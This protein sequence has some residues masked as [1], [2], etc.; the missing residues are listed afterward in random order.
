M[1]LN[2]LHVIFFLVKLIFKT[3]EEIKNNFLLLNVRHLF[4]SCV[5]KKVS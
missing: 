2:V 5:I 3:I 4:F 1:K